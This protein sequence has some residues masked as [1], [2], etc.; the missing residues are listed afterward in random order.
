MKTAGDPTS[1]WLRGVLDLC[2]FAAVSRW[3]LY[4]YE[5][6]RPLAEAGVEA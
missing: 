5:L 1:Q 4:G 3:A 2:L 6:T